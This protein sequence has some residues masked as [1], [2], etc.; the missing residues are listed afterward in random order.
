MELINYV[1]SHPALWLAAA[2]MFSAAASTMPPL[3]E[4][5]GFF[6]Q[7]AYKFIQACAA[8]F[9]KHDNPPG[10]AGTTADSTKGK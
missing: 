7:W 6:A 2:W 4:K 1:L 9:S 3:S 10:I 8:N 5:A